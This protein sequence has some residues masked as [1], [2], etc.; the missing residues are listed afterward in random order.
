MALSDWS[1]VA[2]HKARRHSTPVNDKQLVWSELR[3]ICVREADLPAMWSHPSSSGQI[4]K[5]QDIGI[6]MEIAE[7]RNP[8]PQG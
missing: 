5:V 2:F 8:E 7:G 4:V 3:L 6:K 1:G